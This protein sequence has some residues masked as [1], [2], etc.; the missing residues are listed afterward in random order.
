VKDGVTSGGFLLPRDGWW[1]VALEP[2]CAGARLAVGAEGWDGRG[3]RPLLA[4]IHTFRLV[5]PV[6][7]GGPARL[8]LRDARDGGR[9]EPVLVAPRVAAL[10]EARAPGAVAVSGYGAATAV[11]RFPFLPSD[12]GR[13]RTGRIWALGMNELAWQLVAVDAGGSE[14]GKARPDLPRD[15][16]TGTLALSPEGGSAVLS[17][18]AVELYDAALRRT[19]R[20]ELPP[21]VV[22]SDALFLPDGRLVVV[23]N[24]RRLDLY[25]RDGRLLESFVSWDGGAG[26]FVAPVGVALSPSGLLAV[27]EDTGDV[28]LFRL[29]PDGFSPVHL[30]TLH[31]EPGA[32]PFANDLRGIAFDGPER[33]LLPYNPERPPLLLDLE[34]RRLLSATPEGDLS[35]KGFGSPYRFV[36]TPESLCVVDRTDATLWSVARPEPR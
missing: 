12:V 32:V 26:R 13:D 36:G 9:L 10:P 14:V 23:V 8:V 33:L 19:A 25:T 5:R 1:E 6:S 30:R 35:A 17:L 29:S 15:P 22:A 31:P 2:A 18:D 34:G 24:Q 28:E 3:E 4:G 16:S 11:F 20:W 27:A 7:C 21:G